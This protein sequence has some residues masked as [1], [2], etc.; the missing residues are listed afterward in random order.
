MAQLGKKQQQ[1]I[2]LPEWEEIEIEINVPAE[3][4]TEAQPVESPENVPAE[5][6]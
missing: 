1:E 6:A 4:P 3:A 2:Y 5:V